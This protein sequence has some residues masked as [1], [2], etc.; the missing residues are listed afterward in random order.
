MVN[1]VGDSD[2]GIL[3]EVV[4]FVKIMVDVMSV[5]VVVLSDGLVMVSC[6]FNSNNLNIFF[7]IVQK[8]I[9]DLEQIIVV[10]VECV[11]GK[12]MVIVGGISVFFVVIVNKY[13]LFFI[14]VVQ[15]NNIKD[16]ILKNYYVV[17]VWKEGYYFCYVDKESIVM[18]FLIE[19][20]YG[21]LSVILLYVIDL[22][23]YN[24]IYIV[25]FVLVNSYGDWYL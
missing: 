6:F 24:K 25:I 10:I 15:I 12:I 9:K 17:N 20:N 4:F 3:I 23:M 18:N 7:Y 19:V 5:I 8:I 14:I 13:I 1:G 2:K 22:K 11:M 21:N 16:I